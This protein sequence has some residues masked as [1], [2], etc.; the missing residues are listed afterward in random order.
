MISAWLKETQVSQHIHKLYLK[1]KTQKQVNASLQPLSI[2]YGHN[3]PK[4]ISD[5]PE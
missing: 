1:N 5:Y 2:I 4:L 3:L